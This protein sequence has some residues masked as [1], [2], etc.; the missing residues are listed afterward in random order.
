[1]FNN[2][3][4]LVGLLMNTETTYS[5]IIDGTNSLSINK[6]CKVDFEGDVSISLNFKEDYISGT[7]YDGATIVDTYCLDTLVDCMNLI[8]S[9]LSTVK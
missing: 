2:A 7:V 1:M 8:T 3:I 9:Y 5:I 6:L 4:G